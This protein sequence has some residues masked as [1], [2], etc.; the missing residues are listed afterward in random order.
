MQT[1][2]VLDRAVGRSETIAGRLRAIAV[3]LLGITVVYLV[4]FVNI[5]R[6][7]NATHDTRHATGFPC[8]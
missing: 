4:G 7:H 3:V 1:A 5:P 8:H 6:A 2:R